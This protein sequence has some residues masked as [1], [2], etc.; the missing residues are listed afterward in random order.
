MTEVCVDGHARLSR[1]TSDFDR[2]AMRMR[3]EAID[4]VIVLNDFVGSSESVAVQPGAG[5]VVCG[6]ATA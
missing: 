5:A 3:G 6:G 1:N 4:I 2:I